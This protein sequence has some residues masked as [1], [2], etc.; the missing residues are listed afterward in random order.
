MKT[1]AYI[2]LVVNILLFLITILD[3]A[4]YDIGEW[5]ID[6]LFFGVSVYFFYSY[7]SKKK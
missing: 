4:L 3:Y 6:L 2:L 1:L 5:L 7:V